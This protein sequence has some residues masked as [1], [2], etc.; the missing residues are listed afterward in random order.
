MTAILRALLILLTRFI[1]GGH[2]RWI[3]TRPSPRQRIYFA[4]HGSHLDT[5]VLWAALPGPVRRSTHPVAAADYW[6]RTR[7]RR[8]VALDILGCVLIDRRRAG[9]ADPLEPL[10]ASLSAGRSLV[11]FPEGTRGADSLPGRFRSGLHDLAAAFPA[12]ELVPVYLDN[13]SRAFP[14]GAYLP[15]PISCTAR[16]G[17]P[18]HLG[19]DEGK[20]DFLDRAREAVIA[21]AG[22]GGSA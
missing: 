21:L 16:F 20:G 18:L 14:K 6:G 13:L 1:V 3:G 22:N 15:A 5:I 2:A 4:N 7:L 19:R 10:K 17:A 8:F 12:V 11:L 9:D